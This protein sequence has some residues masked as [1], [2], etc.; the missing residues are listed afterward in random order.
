[1]LWTS[2]AES[3]NNG[4]LD[5]TFT[6]E[7]NHYKNCILLVQADGFNRIDTKIKTIIKL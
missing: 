7:W 4:V 3:L 6:I 1:M 2:S 5:K